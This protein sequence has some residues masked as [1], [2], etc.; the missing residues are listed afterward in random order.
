MEPETLFRA[1]QAEI[2]DAEAI[3]RIEVETWRATYAG[4]L[5]DRVLIGMS[6]KRQRA[7]WIG[8]M[9][10]R[11]GDVIVIEQGAAGIVGFGNCGTQRDG[12]LPYAGEIFTLYV[13]PDAQNR[14]VGK[15]LM[16]AL[17]ARLVAAG[18][19]SALVWVIKANPSRFFYQRM[20]GK[21]VLT[22]RIRVG[23]ELVDAIAYGWP[24]LLALNAAQ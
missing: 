14:G 3:A 22:R 10:Y 6:E 2:E 15:Q 19:T 16:A 8:M 24:D 1:R 23:G 4:M 17:F 7:S 12:A 20:G 21:F 18:R 13:T 11:P 9:R 5:P